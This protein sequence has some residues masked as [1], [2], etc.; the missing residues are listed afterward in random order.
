MFFIFSLFFSLFP[1]LS[2]QKQAVPLV[3]G[4]LKPA[5]EAVRAAGGICI[6]DEVQTGFGRTGTHYWGFE[7]HGVVPD[8][9]TMAKGIGNGLPLG[10]VVTTR[11]VAACLA[12]RLHFNTFGGN[13]VCAAGGEELFLFFFPS[14]FSFF[15]CGRAGV[16]GK[17]LSLSS[18]N[19]SLLSLPLAPFFLS[20][21]PTKT[22]QIQI[23]QSKQAAPSSP[24]STKTGASRLP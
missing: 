20:R 9:V 7:A 17:K 2:D 22:K 15:C 24:R 14:F 16:W 11:E 19:P 4:F 6:A 1:P 23:Q 3:K 13:P 10:A 8:I 18:F 5:Y 21:Y 12:E